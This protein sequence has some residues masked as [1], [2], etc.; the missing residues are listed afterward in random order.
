MVEQAGAMPGVAGAAFV[1]GAPLTQSQIGHT[2][3][4]DDRPYT[5][6]G[7]DS[8]H[9]TNSELGSVGMNLGEGNDTLTFVNVGELLKRYGGGGHP[10]VG[11]ISF[12]RTQVDEARRVAREILAE[13]RS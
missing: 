6:D 2:V 3:L 5:G 9:V 11:A 1:I 13:L 7:N 8:F 12:E 10:R 4:M